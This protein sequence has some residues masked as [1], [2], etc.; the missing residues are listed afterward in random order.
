[1]IGKLS[2]DK[3]L[4]W[5][6]SRIGGDEIVVEATICDQATGHFSESVV[7]SHYPGKS[8]ILSI[9]PTGVGCDIGGYAGDAAP[10]TSLLASTADYLITNPNAVNASDFIKLDDNVVYTEGFSI[11][12]FCQGLVNLYRPYSNRV[13]LIIEK[14]G[15]DGLAAVFNILN[16]V[17]ATHGVD[18]T[19]YVIT[20]RPIGGR[21]V[22]NQSG[23][24]VGTIDNPGVL[25][26]ACEKLTARGVNAIAVTS[27]IQDLPEENYAK[28]FAGE[29]P[30]P[31]GG[32]E[33][34]ISHLIT[35]R[36][37]LPSAHGPLL[38]IKQLDLMHGVVDARGAGEMAS[39]SGLACVLIGLQRAPQ[40]KAR[41]NTRVA[42]ILNINNLLAVVTPAGCLGGIPVLST[43]KYDIPVIAV[44]ENQTIL[45]VTQSEVRLNGVIE[46]RN[47]AE[48]AGI[49]LALKK[50]ISLGS[51][52]RPL[53]TLRHSVGTESEID[54]SLKEVA[55]AK[56]LVA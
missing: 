26:E 53:Q 10:A 3:V 45:N 39:V 30:N 51:I 48:A 7:D 38:N 56:H 43:R 37:Q 5:Y 44:R 29:Y 31:V 22:E 27:H 15:T 20:D 24:F 14:T 36:Y 40:I 9:I 25:F 49:V 35:R 32:V 52:S 8:A 18:I 23:G 19:D 1:M 4:R 46:V 21:C 42:D 2:G 55:Y 33:A 12:L 50:G 54:V 34:V 11:D 47:Y 16:A 17:R 6:I 41:P 13:G 28:H